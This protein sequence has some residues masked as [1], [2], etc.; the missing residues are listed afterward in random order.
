MTLDEALDWLAANG[1][2]PSLVLD[3]LPT[4]DLVITFAESERALSV[5]ALT[6]TDR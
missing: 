2:A 1:Y 6:S 5:R 3:V 4:A